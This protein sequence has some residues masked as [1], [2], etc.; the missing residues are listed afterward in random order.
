M[1]PLCPLFFIMRYGI[2]AICFASILLMMPSCDKNG[3]GAAGDEFQ[4]LEKVT[5]TITDEQIANP[6][7]GLYSGVSFSKETDTPVSSS[8]LLSARKEKRTLYMLEFWLKDYFESDISDA[9]L[10]MI[11]K[12]LEAFRAG[13]MKCILRF[14]YSDNIE[15]LS[16]PYESGPFD[17]TEEWVVR[18]I[19]QLK[20]ILQEFG[21]V[22]YVLQAGFVGCWGEWYYTNNFV[23]NPVSQEDYL[24][25][26]HVCDALLDALPANRQVELRTPMFKMKM[27]GYSVADTITRA[28]AHQPTSKA[29]LGGHNDCYLA[30]A[31]DQGTFNGPASREYWRAET[32]YTIMGGETCAM[33]TYCACENT[34]KDM[35][36][37][38]FS[39]LNISYNRSVIS[40][41]TKND[42]FDEIKNRLGYRLALEDA[43]FTKSPAAGGQFRAV[44]NISNSGFASPMNPR[45]VEFVLADKSGKVIKTYP[46]ESDP[47]FWMPGTTT[48]IDETIEIPSGLSGEYT[49]YLNLPDP[50]STLRENPMFSIQLANENIWDED[51][52]YNKLYS[53]NL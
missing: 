9:Y 42:C 40:H 35:A 51:T 50:A 16:H 28:E 41:W 24:P 18:H 10:Q 7:R 52:G 17:T 8:R 39:Y 21:D 34:L 36:S 15:D 2:F 43:F 13:G 19:T 46:I 45:D 47:R 5:Y 30:S 32:K 14:G 44:L 37:Q 31:N 27:Y 26:K 12:N 4:G 22:I 6:E 33:S 48:R 1:A 23:Q 38:H 20:P 3:S 25:R 29:R 53:F 49:L 11:R